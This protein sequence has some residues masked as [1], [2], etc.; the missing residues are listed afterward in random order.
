MRNGCRDVKSDIVCGAAPADGQSR[1]RVST[2]YHQLVGHC[3]DTGG[4]EAYVVAILR[5]SNLR[6]ALD[7][8]LIALPAPS[9]AATSML[10]VAS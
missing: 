5:R 9:M 4:D 8:K 1:R 10:L 6:I 2:T 3:L 7:H